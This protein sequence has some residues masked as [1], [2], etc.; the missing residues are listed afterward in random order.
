[1]CRRHD[2]VTPSAAGWAL[3]TA[4][5]PDFAHDPL[6]RL[7]PLHRWPLV[8]RRR[9]E[10]EADAAAGKI[11]LGLPL[12]PAAGK[13]RIALGLRR[14]EVAAI[15][16]PPPL[17]AAR[18]AAPP[19]WQP[20][21]AALLALTP[22]VRCFGSLAWQH[23]TG[24]AYLAPTSDLDLLWDLP[25]APLAMLDG[26]ARIAEAA[27][28]RIDGEVLGPWGGVQWRELRSA[29]PVAVKGDKGG[30][31]LI[32]RATFCEGRR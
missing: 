4:A 24:L 27:P 6:L 29:D 21:I 20:A 23:V 12:P 17:A 8:V 5:L 22:G 28:M 19:A 10:G 14:A 30:V 11:P 1:M 2:L 15:G 7:W 9:G 16:P 31:A 13:R 18:D 3:L 26:I 25:P 32:A